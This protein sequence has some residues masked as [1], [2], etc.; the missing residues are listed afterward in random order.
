MTGWHV[1]EVVGEISIETFEQLRSVLDSLTS[2]L[3]VT[4]HA[5]RII[6]VNKAWSDFGEREHGLSGCGVGSNYLEVCSRTEGS[7]SIEA[8]A[9]LNAMRRIL[10]GETRY[11]ELEY[12]CRSATEERWFVVRI[13][14]YE[15]VTPAGLVVSHSNVTSRKH[16]EA[17]AEQL[18]TEATNRDQQDRQDRETDS[19]D[20]LSGAPLGGITSKAVGL[21]PL[22]KSRK[23]SF[24][25]LA[26]LYGAVL[27]KAVECR[28]IRTRLSVS[29]ELKRLA[30]R[31]GQYR[32]GPRDV[33]DIHLASL[34]KRYAEHGG[35]KRQLYADEARVI[36][37]E[38]MGNL[39][40]HYQKLIA[41]DREMIHARR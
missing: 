14:P 32:A 16:R 39:A 12:P 31:L 41:T 2:H 1:G 26:E 15:G 18:R 4:D 34:K 30:E 28:I 13:T 17:I 10:S 7:D 35:A 21:L 38:L 37:L 27:D 20:S 5:G 6:F 8:T 23:E 22:S 36:V 24:D 40:Y 11:F 9:V 25:S 3:S 33:I 19:L 29:Q